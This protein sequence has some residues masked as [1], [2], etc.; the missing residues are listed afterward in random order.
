MYITYSFT[1]THCET[2]KLK[3]SGFNPLTLMNQLHLI[4]RNKDKYEMKKTNRCKANVNAQCFANSF[5]ILWT[6]HL[7]WT[8]AGILSVSRGE[9]RKALLISLTC[10]RGEE[11]RERW[12]IGWI[13]V[14]FSLNLCSYSPSF[15]Y[16]C[17]FSLSNHLPFFFLSLFTLKWR[18]SQFQFGFVTPNQIQ[19]CTK[20]A[21]WNSVSISKAK[22]NLSLS[23]ENLAK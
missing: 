9:G 5:D 12:L 11:N 18:F 19:T 16:L 14:W 2:L 17:W 8:I 13:D 7:P 22:A 4:N 1:I 20:H 10:T 23:S 3:R 15:S 6:L 21:T